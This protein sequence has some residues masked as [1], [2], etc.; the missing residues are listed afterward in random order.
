MLHL[1][2]KGRK[3]V[4]KI[5]G[6]AIIICGAML[7]GSTS[8]YAAIPV[9]EQPGYVIKDRIAVQG[10]PQGPE[11]K[12]LNPKELESALSFLYT[13]H[14]Q[15][16]IF[17]AQQFPEKFRHTSMKGF[18]EIDR[19]DIWYAEP[20]SREQR[21]I[22]R[23]FDDPAMFCK[24][25][26]VDRCYFIST[27][28]IEKYPHLTSS[29][30][31]RGGKI[32]YRVDETEGTSVA[33]QT[34]WSV[35]GSVGIKKSPADLSLNFTYSSSTTRTSSVSKSRSN[36]VN[37]DVPNNNFGRI[38]EYFNGGIYVGV[39]LLATEGLNSGTLYNKEAYCF[40][41]QMW[42]DVCSPLAD[43]IPI[44]YNYIAIPM[45]ATVISDTS[46]SAV[47]SLLRTWK[48]GTPAPQP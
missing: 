46:S 15:D 30:T 13:S 10:L 23:T 34:G 38:D 1:S 5:S 16:R 26:G 42:V 19:R 36:I 3:N 37:Y 9:D 40:M 33:N 44:E 27:K 7:F 35:G 32:T 11:W 21:A 45:K 24:R 39:M 8:A 41:N 2:L 22:Y 17:A 43:M 47:T 4:K 18:K 6:I 12:N 28:V 14:Y 29:Y 20:G 31:V 25:Y 48:A